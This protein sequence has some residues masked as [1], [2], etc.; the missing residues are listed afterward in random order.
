[1]AARVK[2]PS[3]MLENNLFIVKHLVN[4]QKI[5]SVSMLNAKL[6]VEN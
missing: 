3:D 1:M 6:E 5:I 2:D 4:V